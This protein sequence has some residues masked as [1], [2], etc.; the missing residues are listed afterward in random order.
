M[1]LSLCLALLFLCASYANGKLII[2]GDSLSD[3]GNLFAFT[4]GYPPE[5]YGDT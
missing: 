1:L 2:F 3:Q 4:G 5:P